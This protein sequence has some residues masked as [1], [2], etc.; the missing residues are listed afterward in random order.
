MRYRASDLH[1][2][3]NLNCSVKIYFRQQKSTPVIICKADAT[4]SN[5]FDAEVAN[6]RCVG[7]NFH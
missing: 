1:L 5:I 2:F 4:K 3:A 7:K 6:F